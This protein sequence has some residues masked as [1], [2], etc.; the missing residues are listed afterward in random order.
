V[1]AR[2]YLKDHQGVGPI[3][4]L[5]AEIV[6]DQDC[7]AQIRLQLPVVP[8]GRISNS[9]SVDQLIENREADR[10]PSLAG[11]LANASASEVLPAPSEPSRTTLDLARTKSAVQRSWILWESRPG[12]FAVRSGC[13]VPML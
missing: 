3:K 5:G 8:A 13:G 2:E 10:E 4:G 11:G 1:S 12:R 6:H 7:R 9:Q